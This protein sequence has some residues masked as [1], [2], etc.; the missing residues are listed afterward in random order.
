MAQQRLDNY[1]RAYRKRAGLSQDDVSFL[2]G[3]KSGAQVSRYERGARK[4]TLENALTF[5]AILSVPA[6]ELFAG[7]YERVAQAVSRRAAKLAERLKA[8]EHGAVRARRLRT[9]A[10]LRSSGASPS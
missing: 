5:E 4:P 2:L 9:V 1:L 10:A 7:R 6:R 3:Y 8:P